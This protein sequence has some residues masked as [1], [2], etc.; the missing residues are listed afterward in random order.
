MKMCVPTV[1]LSIL[2][3][4]IIYILTFS[5]YVYLGDVIINRILVYRVN[6][7]WWNYIALFADVRILIIKLY[8]FLLFTLFINVTLL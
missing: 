2:A 7:L 5:N 4:I 3:K 8:T 1:I 6:M